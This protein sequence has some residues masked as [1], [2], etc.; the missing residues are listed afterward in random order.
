MFIS[1]LLI[2]CLAPGCTR[3]PDQ[4]AAVNESHDDN[5]GSQLTLPVEIHIL[6]NGL[7]VLIHKDQSTPFVTVNLSA[8]AGSGREHA[9]E[10]GAAYLLQYLLFQAGSGLREH[11]M[12][13][14][15]N[16]GADTAGGA[17]SSSVDYDRLTLTS[18]FPA[19]ALPTILWLES[20]RLQG[21]LDGLSDEVFEKQRAHVREAVTAAQEKPHGLQND[22]IS[23]HLYLRSHPYARPVTATPADI[24]R[25][26]PGR[27][28]DFYRRNVSPQ[29]AVLVISGNVDSA[30]SL[31][32]VQK[33]FAPLKPG[34]ST[35]LIVADDPGPQSRRVVTHRSDAPAKQVFV[36]KG[37]SVFSPQLVALEM[38]GAILTGGKTARL[39]EELVRKEKLATHVSSSVQAA[40]LGSE[41][42]IEVFPTDGSDP[43]R[44]AAL[45]AKV[46][47]DTAVSGPGETDVATARSRAEFE[48]FRTL[49]SSAGPQGKAARFAR[50]LLM[51]PATAGVDS[52]MLAREHQNIVAQT[53]AS[54][55]ESMRTWLATPAALEIRF[56]PAEFRSAGVAPPLVLPPV[57]PGKSLPAVLPGFSRKELPNGLDLIVFN[58]SGST[59][60]GSPSQNIEVDLVIKTTD[61]FESEDNAGVSMLTAKALL[62]GT[63]SRS[64]FQVENAVNSF[65]GS[66]STDG[67]KYGARVS[68]NGLKRHIEGIFELLADVAVNP[69][70]PE[71]ELTAV[72]KIVAEKLARDQQYPQQTANLMFG[73]ILFAGGHPG[74]SPADGTPESV[75]KIPPAAL[76]DHHAKFW[77]PNNAALI[78]SGPVTIDEAERLANKHF[79]FWSRRNLEAVTLQELPGPDRTYAFLVQIPEMTETLIRMGSVA[80]YRGHADEPGLQVLSQMLTNRQQESGGQRTASV[81]MQNRYFGYWMQSATTD[82]S[83]AVSAVELMQAGLNALANPPKSEGQSIQAELVRAQND[84]AR[85]FL[86]SF[87]TSAFTNKMTSALV[88]SGIA[89]ERLNTWLPGLYQTSTATI[90]DLATRYGSSNRRIILF[91]G[92]VTGIEQELLRKKYSDI[93][94]LDRDGKFIRRSGS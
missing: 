24:A 65:G 59:E 39:Y 84:L 27:V 88:S 4:P 23:R 66:L 44:I 38:T 14:F 51:E 61:L 19:H 76:K 41:F 30:A 33:F 43:E 29:N 78:V 50:T 15:A 32:T 54:I 81:L 10:E 17:V 21:F 80:P 67:S 49:E 8:L 13:I 73:K 55:A 92:A 18:T 2:A 48:F 56:L 45:V 82:P 34:T 83:R 79:A 91:M 31:A 35:S 64:A 94:T 5:S 89:P 68:I 69:V 74:G 40:R 3:K 26:T 12:Q 53:P 11:V 46:L 93:V 1:A 57:A 72:R 47:A 7:R 36:W 75:S 77:V 42:L 90:A 16:A 25:L 9:G 71:A 87:E 22:L 37:P 85:S 63:K 28:Q 60:V 6:P 20:K 86:K 52:R 62:A 58:R 70:F